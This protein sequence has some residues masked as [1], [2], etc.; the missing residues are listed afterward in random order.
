MRTSSR[1]MSFRR[2]FT[3]SRMLSLDLRLLFLSVRVALFVDVDPAIY[4]AHL[5]GNRAKVRDD[6]LDSDDTATNISADFNAMSLEDIPKLR[7]LH[8]NFTGGDLAM[9]YL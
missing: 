8:V 6:S 5:A 1:L 7:P 2:F 3:I 9:W 4:Y